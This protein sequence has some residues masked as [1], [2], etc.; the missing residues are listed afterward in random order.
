MEGLVMNDALFTLTE[1]DLSPITD[2]ISAN[3]PIIVTAGV[4]IIITVAAIR[5]IPKLIKVFTRG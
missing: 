1:L 2:T 5:L 3:A 4:G